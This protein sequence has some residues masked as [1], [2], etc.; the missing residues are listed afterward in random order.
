MNFWKSD[1]EIVAVILLIASCS[2]AEQVV[3]PRGSA[4]CVKAGGAW[5][6]DKACDPG[7]CERS[8]K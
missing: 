6:G 8:A 2:V 3:V 4:E 1:W 7:Y 5:H